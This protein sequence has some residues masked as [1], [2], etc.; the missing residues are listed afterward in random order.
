MNTASAPPP[1]RGET[2]TWVGREA[3]SG[4]TRTNSSSAAESGVAPAART[5]CERSRARTGSGQD[6]GPLDVQAF[7]RV[8]A[9][10]EEVREAA[11]HGVDA[12]RGVHAEEARRDGVEEPAVALEGRAAPRVGPEDGDL[13]DLSVAHDGRHRDDGLHPGAASRVQEQPP[14][15]RR[16]ARLEDLAQRLDD[17]RVLGLRVRD[18]SRRAALELARGL[19]EDADGPAVH[20]PDPAVA[21][22]GEDGE[23][24]ERV[25]RR[26]ERGP[27][28]RL[29]PRGRAPRRPGTTRRESGSRPAPRAA[30]QARRRPR[31][32]R[33]VRRR[34]AAGRKRRESSGRTRRQFRTETP[35][36]EPESS[37]VAWA[38]L[39]ASARA[40]LSGRD[41]A[42]FEAEEL[43]ARAAGRPRSW[44]HARRREPADAAAAAAFDDLVARRAAGEPL[45]YL[46]GEWEFLGR[47]F[48]V[49]P[50]ALI[51][52]G[53][54][55]GIVE[56]ARRAAPDAVRLVDL[57]TGSGVL[58]VSL[59]LERP[60]R[61]RRR[62]RPLPRRA[63]PRSRER[64]APRRRRTAS[65]SVASDW[66]SALG[67]ARA[68]R[69][70]R[71][72]PAVRPAHGPAAPLEDRLRVRARTS[73]STAARTGST[74][75]ARSSRRSRRSSRRARPSS[76]SSATARRTTSRRSSR[77]RRDSASSASASTRRGSRARRRRSAREGTP[78]RPHRRAIGDR[79][80]GCAAATARRDGD[81]LRRARSRA[82]R[83]GASGHGVFEDLLR[84]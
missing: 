39:L 37:A 30:P 27:H 79:V 76:S 14:R 47:T 38:D 12:A 24:L 13:D 56:E 1:A 28:A 50:R 16:P 36:T 34:R 9:A 31:G 32:R 70:R 26:A 61:A 53:E 11:V 4:V 10:P 60:A 82:A 43:L 7:E 54:T 6:L 49:D 62:A 57:G 74:R 63:R 44:F 48:A 83:G 67:D 66:L 29:R 17:L 23:R 73:R 19:P 75:C 20:V 15:G 40:R 45:Q 18:D 77:P 69:P 35:M 41:H 2:R 5:A 65:A 84:R 59:A 33:K 21:V 72:E 68:L 25:E 51:P 22:D 42:P 78:A 64:A 80:V 71:R 81:S 55:E 58:A 46:L 52:R 3:P 8:R